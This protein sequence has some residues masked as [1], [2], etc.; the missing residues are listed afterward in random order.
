MLAFLPSALSTLVRISNTLRLLLT[1]KLLGVRLVE[2][3][4]DAA[5]VN[6]NAV[7]AGV[8]DGQSGVESHSL[9]NIDFKSHAH[10]PF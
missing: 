4:C 2:I 1:H 7:A 10:L 9:R 8:A 5:S 6:K 3:V